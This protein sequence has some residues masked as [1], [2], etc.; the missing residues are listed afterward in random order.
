MNLALKNLSENCYFFI[1]FLPKKELLFMDGYNCFHS[2]FGI[3]KVI[4]LKFF[5]CNETSKKCPKSLINIFID[6]ILNIKFF[7]L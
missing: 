1:P 3:F 4:L 5:I 7:M 6:F 2:I